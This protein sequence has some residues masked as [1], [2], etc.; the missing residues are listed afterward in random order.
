MPDAGV[1]HNLVIVKIRKRYSGQGMKVINSLFGAGQ[2]MF[3]KYLIVVNGDVD[4]RDYLTLTEFIFKN[5]DFSKDLLFSQGPLD[6][7]DHS[8]DSVAFGGK[9]G[10]D[11]TEKTK[12]EGQKVI[13][14]G[15]DGIYV[16]DYVFKEMI[17]SNLINNYQSGLKDL[18]LPFLI[19]SVD[20]FHEKEKI[21]KLKISLNNAEEIRLYEIIL[22]VDSTIEISNYFN[23]AWQVLGNSDPLRDHS[24]I[25]VK[26]LLIDG[27]IKAFRSG[28]FP[29]RWPNVVCSDI[30]TIKNVDLK[31]D[32]LEI[33]KL[34]QSPSLKAINMAYPGEEEIKF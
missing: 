24:Y 14:D 11:A 34:I 7:L 6:V 13:R 29:R 27:S 22:L 18:N 1:A 16:T 28:G 33:G 23:V 31:W 4:I 20:N 30:E 26:S 3:T 12:E 8:A 10:I 9:L 19:L 32:K 2:M 17:S 5:T 25:G 21:N 15:H